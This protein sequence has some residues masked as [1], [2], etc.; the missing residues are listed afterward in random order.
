MLEWDFGDHKV[1]W[2]EIGVWKFIKNSFL[3]ETIF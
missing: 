3:S 2:V 1:E